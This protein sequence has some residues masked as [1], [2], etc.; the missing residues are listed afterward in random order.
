M[1][2]GAYQRLGLHVSATA[3]EVIAAARTKVAST[4]RTRAQREARHAYYREMLVYHHSARSVYDMAM[5]GSG[6]DG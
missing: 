2:F 1:M 5:S 3:R 6:T 4:G